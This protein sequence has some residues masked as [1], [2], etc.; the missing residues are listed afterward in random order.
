M[1]KGRLAL[2]F[3]LAILT[4]SITA[5]TQQPPPK[6]EAKTA[7]RN[8]T[9]Q[10]KQTSPGVAVPP[11]PEKSVPLQSPTPEKREPCVCREVAKADWWTRISNLAMAIGT[12][13]LALIGAI[14][15]CIAIRTLRLIGI[16]ANAARAAAR[17]AFMN[18][19]AVINSERAWV[20]GE[21]VKIEKIGIIRYEFKVTNQGNT[22]ARIFSYDVW[23]GRFTEGTE[24]PK[25]GFTHINSPEDVLLGGGSTTTLRDDWD[26]GHL[27]SGVFS[28]PETMPKGAFC[29]TIK[30]GDVVSE[31]Q[32][33]REHQTSFVYIYDGFLSRIERRAEYNDYT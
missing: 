10:D 29:V 8:K 22:P 3:V 32:Q 24:L 27:F 4:L 14:A 18:A 23:Y 33:K 5:V 6:Q 9:G 26:I 12:V 7:A 13:V 20:D 28:D 19:Q 1:K 17:A 11:E 2:L 15:A 30:Y 16:Q 21:L 31:G 25:Q